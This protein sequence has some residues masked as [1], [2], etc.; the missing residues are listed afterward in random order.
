MEWEREINVR[1]KGKVKSEKDFYEQQYEFV[2]THK[3]YCLYSK[4]KRKKNLIANIS[5]AHKKLIES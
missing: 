4:D 2:N 1:L 3:F 5:I